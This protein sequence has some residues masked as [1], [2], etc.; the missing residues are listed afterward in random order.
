MILQTVCE[1]VNEI[2]GI[3]LTSMTP[4]ENNR[5]AQTNADRGEVFLTQRHL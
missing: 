4:A 3:P 1:K 5:A 2:I